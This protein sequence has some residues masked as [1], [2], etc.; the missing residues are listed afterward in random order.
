MEGEGD[1]RSAVSRFLALFWPISLSTKYGNRGDGT[2][3]RQ[4][5]SDLFAKTFFFSPS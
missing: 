4:I 1:L 2:Y 3:W 5:P